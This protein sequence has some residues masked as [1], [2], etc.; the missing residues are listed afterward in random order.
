MA[1]DRNP[2]DDDDEDD[3]PR[4]PRRPRDDDDDDEDDR[5]RKPRRKPKADNTVKVLLILGGVLVVVALICSGTAYGIYRSLARKV[6]DAQ[7]QFEA[8]MAKQAAEDDSDKGRATVAVE[9]FVAELEAG[10]TTA[11]YALTSA[12]YRRRTTEAAFAATVRPI[13][14]DLPDATPV[15]ANEFA[16]DTGATYTFEIWAGTKAVKITAVKEGGKWAVDAFTVT[17]Q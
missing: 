4:R 11:A 6:A 16:P 1:R 12:G 8:D 3:R 14:A 2:R 15:L 13:A 17:A 5:P 7:K 9:A 10:R